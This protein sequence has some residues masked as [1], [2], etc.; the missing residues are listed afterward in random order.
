MESHVGYKLP[1]HRTEVV[2]ILGGECCKVCPLEER[3]DGIGK[4][5]VFD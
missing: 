3:L 1:L 4:L 2:P 5:G